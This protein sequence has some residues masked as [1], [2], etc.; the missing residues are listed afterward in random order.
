MPDYKDAPK[1]NLGITLLTSGCA[2]VSG[3]LFVHPMDVLKVRLQLSGE[4]GASKLYKN[5]FDALQKIVRNEGMMKLW[6]GLSAGVLRQA[7]YTTIRGGVYQSLRDRLSDN[8]ARPQSFRLRLFCGMVGGM[9]GS[10]LSNPVEV[11]LVRMQ[12][13]GRLPVAARR[14]Y[15]SVWDALR[16]IVKEEGVATCW[17]GCS[18]TVVRAIVV[19][20]MQLGCYDQAKDVY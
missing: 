12:A 4:N 13:D 10:M 20:M 7:T 16:R 2:G 8:G 9:V 1:L 19:N 3:W 14:H 18:P 6:S 15:G 5:S 17:R 11:A